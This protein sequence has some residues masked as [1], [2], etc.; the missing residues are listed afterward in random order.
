MAVA[1]RIH[2]AI[3]YLL[4]N[5]ILQ[6]N[7]YIGVFMKI[8]FAFDKPE[9]D[10]SPYVRTIMYEIHKRA[11]EWKIDAGI[12]LFWSDQCFSYD[13]VHIMFPHF[14]L[15]QHNSPS[16]R[17]SSEE[18]ANHLRLL[19]QKGI[20]IVSTCHNLRPHY[21]DDSDAI[22]SYDLVYQFSTMI[23]HLGPYSLEQGKKLYPQAQHVLLEHPVYDYEFPYIP[24]QKEAQEKLGLN[25]SY[26][27]IL[28]F[29]AFRDDEERNLVVKVSK[30]F[31]SQR[32]RI[33]APSFYRVRNRRNKVIVMAQWCKKTFYKLRYP[34]IFNRGGFVPPS[35][36]PF[37]L[38]ACDIA[39]LQRLHILNSGNLPLNYYFG[40]VVVGP[41]IGNVGPILQTTG[42]PTFEPYQ[43]Y[44]VMKA[45][46]DGF[47]LVKQGQGKRNRE[48][49]LQHWTTD[50]IGAQ[51]YAYY[52]FLMKQN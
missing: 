51:Q 36:L 13:I 2:Y 49:A 7:S 25:P 38:K 1:R 44:S 4:S 34:T 19:Q 40:N 27:Y 21:N 9:T 30:A 15:L 6:E 46:Q 43:D 39:L 3:V 20:L 45:I 28:C 52:Q 23:F 48:Y 5:K 14:L 42:N 18:L 35:L 17:H 32:V 41:R 12:K 8:L 26:R 10:P 50:T 31:K 37:Y 29:G 33:L 16:E 22:A 24:T 11:P 47:E